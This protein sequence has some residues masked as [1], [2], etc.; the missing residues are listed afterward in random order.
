MPDIQIDQEVYEWL[1]E[2][3]R[4]FE[5][6]PN[7]VM[8]K[9]AGLDAGPVYVDKQRAN[10]PSGRRDRSASARQLVRQEGLDVRKAYYHWEGTW[11]Q[12]VHEFPAALFD[13]YGYVVLKSRTEYLNHP[14]IG[15]S[16]KTNIPDGIA[17]F[18]NYTKM[19]RPAF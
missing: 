8:R 10:T 6:T 17:S 15:G 19:S 9:I 18:E 13:Q 14:K 16:E 1:Q 3:A 4:A 2:Q 7:S 11:F 5:D 12:R